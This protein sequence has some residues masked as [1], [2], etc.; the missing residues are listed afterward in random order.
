[1]PPEPTAD[2]TTPTPPTEPTPPAEPPSTEPSGRIEP[3]PIAPSGRIDSSVTI[4]GGTFSGPVAGG[5]RAHAVQYAADDEVAHGVERLRALLE[6]HRGGIDAAA[7]AA[8]T[9]S[10][11]TVADVH[12]PVPARR[13]AAA[14]FVGAVAAVPALVQAGTALLGLLA[15]S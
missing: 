7:H 13:V 10:L 14:R 4:S 9:R 12:R 8:A 2:D 5:Y 3:P 11:D 6:A 15:G 1:M